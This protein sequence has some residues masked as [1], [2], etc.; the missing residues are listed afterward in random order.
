MKSVIGSL[1]KN[2][3]KLTSVEDIENMLIEEIPDDAAFDS[4]TE[5]WSDNNEFDQLD[6]SVN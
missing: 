4:D 3:M 1:Q 2:K 6:Y 5:D